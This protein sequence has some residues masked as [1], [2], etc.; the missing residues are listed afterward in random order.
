MRAAIQ[1]LAPEE[2]IRGQSW[3]KGISSDNGKTKHPSQAER[4]RY[5]VQVRGGNVDQ[6]KE[7]DSVLEESIGRISRDTYNAGSKS[8]HAGAA[9]EQLRKLTGWVFAVLDEVLPD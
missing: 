8:F 3:F 7:L 4:T 9:Q 1:K 2:E 6:V 5:A